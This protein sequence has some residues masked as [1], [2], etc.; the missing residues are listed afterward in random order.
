MENKYGIPSDLLRD[1]MKEVH[2]HPRYIEL[3]KKYANYQKQG[4]FIQAIEMKKYIDKFI[5][6]TLH[7]IA[8]RMEEVR[9]PMVEILDM[10]SE[11]KRDE[12]YSKLYAVMFLLDMLED[13]CMTINE[14]MK[15][16][17][18]KIDTLN[19]IREFG[20]A[21]GNIMRFILSD[22]DYEATTFAD[23]ADE[24]LDFFNDKSMKI[25]KIM[26]ERKNSIHT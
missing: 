13:A 15:P 4:K 1:I 10:M 12:T 5:D 9:V 23:F 7:R 21:T 16:F 17:D 14:N 24:V 8:N 25:Y 3:N 26:Q 22:N 20:K 2:S 19:E 11:E 18:A 6:E